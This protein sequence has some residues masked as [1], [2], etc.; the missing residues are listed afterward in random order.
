M[1]FKDTKFIVL[2]YSDTPELVKSLNLPITDFEDKI[3]NSTM[4]EDFE[5]VNSDKLMIISTEELIGR[6]MDRTDDIIDNERTVT[7]HPSAKAWKEIIP[8]LAKKLKLN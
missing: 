8:A 7:V 4:W 3:L 6:K 2:L 1:N 5:K